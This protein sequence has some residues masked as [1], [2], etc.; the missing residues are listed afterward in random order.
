MSAG[1][2]NQRVPLAAV[3]VQKELLNLRET[4]EPGLLT[5]DVIS[6]ALSEQERKITPNTV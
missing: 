6:T 3:H 1:P 5:H 2:S 4:P